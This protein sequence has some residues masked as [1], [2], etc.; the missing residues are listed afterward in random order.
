MNEEHWNCQID[1]S[2]Y[3]SSVVV[4]VLERYRQNGW[5]IA[6]NASDKLQRSF[7]EIKEP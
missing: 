4:K 3:P 6:E 2:I 1:V 7:I 5:I